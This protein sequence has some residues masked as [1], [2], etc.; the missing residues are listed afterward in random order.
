M[1]NIN[2][3]LD[4]FVATSAGFAVIIFLIVL[5]VLWFLLPFAVF[6]T[7]GRLQKIIDELHSLNSAILQLKTEVSNIKRNLND[8]GKDKKD[9]IKI[10]I[11]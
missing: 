5:A 2:S 6:G 9:D 11:D 3:T 8:N 4:S 1:N 10:S 7:Q